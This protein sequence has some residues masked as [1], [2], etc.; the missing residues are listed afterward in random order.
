VP[1]PLRPRPLALAALVALAICAAPALA[2]ESAAHRAVT[3][4]AVAG[5]APGPL[6]TAFAAHLAGLEQLSVEPDLIREAGDREEGR[7]HYIDLEYYGRD[8]FAALNPSEAATAAR[9][10][11]RTL[12]KSGTLPWTIEADA[13][14]L[15]AA[16][17]AG[18]CREA[19]RLAG[20]LSHYVADASQPLHTTKY[21]D[22]YP[23]DRG[24]HLRMER[25]AD[26]YLWQ[27]ERAAAPR[28]HV[29]PID[30][31]WTPVIAELRASY[32]LVPQTMAADRAA[33]AAAQSTAQYQRLLIG[34]ER[35]WIVTQL[36]A[37]AS[38]LASI[39]QLEWERG[40]ARSI[41]ASP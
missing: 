9:F 27:L 31:V 24:I 19:M 41:C 32:A 4:L 7:R 26:A 15:A 36:A 29:E 30:D 22:G 6:K 12:R 37:A 11:A 18:D 34:S 25:S 33:R 5:L 2:W 28:V 40:G 38:V 10:G 23:Q 20:F 17:R 8:P 35:G 39:W 14:R 16:W 3:R 1:H 21:F 13:E